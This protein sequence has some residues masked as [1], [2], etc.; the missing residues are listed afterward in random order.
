MS[1]LSTYGLAMAMSFLT[2]ALVVQRAYAGPDESTAVVKT[3][4]D[5][6]AV[7]VA[8]EGQTKIV[9]FSEIASEGDL[10]TGLASS[11]SAGVSKKDLTRFLKN[12]ELIVSFL[13]GLMPPGTPVKL[14]SMRQ[15]SAGKWVASVAF[16][17]GW[18]NEMYIDL[19]ST[20][21]TLGFGVPA[22]R[23][24]HALLLS[25]EEVD[26]MAPEYDAV[27]RASG[28][29]KSGA[30]L[31]AD[32]SRK[33]PG[34][35]NFELPEGV[36]PKLAIPLLGI[37]GMSNGSV[38]ITVICKGESDV[39]KVAKAAPWINWEVLKECFSGIRVSEL[40][41]T[42]RRTEFENSVLSRLNAAEQWSDDP[43]T[44]ERVMVRTM[45]VPHSK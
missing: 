13:R 20:I 27:L 18:K 24:W 39:A 4:C 14:H 26:E 11:D 25:A 10:R 19:D 45:A 40:H 37:S 21:L 36:D 23:Y 5:I 30:G 12:R 3:V 1:R 41:E 43:P 9:R 33:R 17:P 32:G 29:R 15:E 7:E 42:S 38:A 2:P 44:I 16:H 22:P 28:A 8:H 34:V 6:A 31:W 35:T